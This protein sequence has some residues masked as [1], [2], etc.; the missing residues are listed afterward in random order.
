MVTQLTTGDQ[1]P[2]LTLTNQD[3]AEIRLADLLDAPDARVVVYFYPKAFTPGCTTQACDF[4]DNLAALSAQGVRV[5]GVS[6]DDVDTLAGFASEYNV[7]YDLLSDPGSATAKQWG[8]WGMRT[9]NGETSEG[10][11]RSTVVVGGDGRVQI[12]EYGV[13][14]QGSVSRLRDQ[15]A[16]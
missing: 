6:A 1:A 4:R 3:G 2:S 8:A 15:L 14:A 10:P 7:N 5:L 16:I 9:I 12:A 13:D 11:L